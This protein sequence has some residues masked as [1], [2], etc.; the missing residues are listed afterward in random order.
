[1]EIAEINKTLNSDTLSQ[2]ELKEER[3]KVIEME[4]ILE[5]MK[6]HIAKGTLVD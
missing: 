2:D 3:R 4:S 5:K 1:M 6:E